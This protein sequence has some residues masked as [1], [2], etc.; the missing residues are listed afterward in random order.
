MGPRLVPKIHRPVGSMPRNVFTPEYGPSDGRVRLAKRDHEFEPT[1]YCAKLPSP[2]SLSS[3]VPG[4]AFPSRTNRSRSAR[5][6]CA[7]M[8]VRPG[9]FL[10]VCDAGT[11]CGD[12]ASAFMTRYERKSGFDW[13]I[14]VGRADLHE[15]LPWSGR[16]DWNFSNHQGA[17]KGSTTTAFMVFRMGIVAT[18]LIAP[19]PVW[20][21]LAVPCGFRS[22][23]RGSSA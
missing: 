17:P 14:T 1:A 20:R 21:L 8:R 7:A 19:S 2:N 18:L 4:T 10:H 22:G 3:P 15:G 11:E 16:G 23:R 6:R 9:S 12:D 5:T 13:P